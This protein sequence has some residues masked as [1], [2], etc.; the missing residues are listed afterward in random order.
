MY[1]SGY[2]T[3]P[4]SP[5]PPFVVFS[6]AHIYTLTHMP[7][8][9]ISQWRQERSHVWQREKEKYLFIFMQR[10]PCPP[11]RLYLPLLSHSFCLAFS[12]LIP[13]FVAH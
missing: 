3:L 1:L 2:Q 7:Y 12:S 8:V 11:P 4:T 13:L 5:H 9:F 10:L 6:H